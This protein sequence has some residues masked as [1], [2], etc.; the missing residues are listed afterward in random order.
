MKAP[1]RGPAVAFL[2]T[3]RSYHSPRKSRFARKAV[4]RLRTYSLVISMTG[5]IDPV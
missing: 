4:L 2:A 5:V 1:M 3:E